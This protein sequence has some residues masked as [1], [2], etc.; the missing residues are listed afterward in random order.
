MVFG[1]LSEPRHTS[2]GRLG[3]LWLGKIDPP[4]WFCMIDAIPKKG[5]S[6]MRTV[7][8][9]FVSEAIYC[10]RMNGGVA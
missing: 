2:N 5:I 6:L 3:K 4:H 1:G 8:P 10:K 9:L 7:S